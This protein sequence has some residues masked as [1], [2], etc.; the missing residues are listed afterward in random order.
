MSTAV[1]ADALCYVKHCYH[2]TPEG[3]PE[4]QDCITSLYIQSYQL[5]L[6]TCQKNYFLTQDYKAAEYV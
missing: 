2:Y 6:G 5:N 4:Q 3:C 1:L